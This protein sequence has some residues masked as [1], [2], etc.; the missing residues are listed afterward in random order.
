MNIR[1]VSCT[2]RNLDHP[3]PAR[4]LYT[5]SALFRKARAYCEHHYDAWYILSAKHGLVHPDQVVAPYDI[6]L[7]RMS[8]VERCAWERRLSERL[9]R[10]G[11]GHI[12]YAHAGKDYI[13]HLS[14]ICLV[15]IL[16]GHSLGNRLRWYNQQAA[17][18]GWECP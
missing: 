5:A 12:F 11:S 14:S 9:R 1:L 3:C 13:V 18:E 4:D 8:I 16:E 15:N 17:R 7:K 6:T 10:L 2:K